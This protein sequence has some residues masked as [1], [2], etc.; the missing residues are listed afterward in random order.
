VGNLE[1]CRDTGTEYVQDA[2]AAKE[3]WSL[4]TWYITKG[5]EKKRKNKEKWNECLTTGSLS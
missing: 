5:Y 4:I 1:I 2:E 3:P